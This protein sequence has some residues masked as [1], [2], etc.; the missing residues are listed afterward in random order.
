MRGRAPAGGAPIF[1]VPSVNSTAKCQSTCAANQG[2]RWWVLR[3]TTS[4]PTAPAFTAGTNNP[5]MSCELYADVGGA[6]DCATC[7]MGPKHCPGMSDAPTEQRAMSPATVTALL[8]GTA[9]FEH[10]LPLWATD[11]NEDV[12]E[13]MARLDDAGYFSGKRRIF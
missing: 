7:M 9:K 5:A 12:F 3:N 8:S 1:T 11:E 13:K 6:K 10:R 2:C 4:S